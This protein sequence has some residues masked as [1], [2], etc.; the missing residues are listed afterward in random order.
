MAPVNLPISINHMAF[1]PF[2][3]HVIGK[4]CQSDHVIIEATNIPQARKFAEARYPDCKIGAVRS[5]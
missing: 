5:A 3:V 1:K 2:K 4:G